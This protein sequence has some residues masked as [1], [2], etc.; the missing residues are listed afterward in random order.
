MEEVIWHF[1]ELTIIQWREESLELFLG[2][3]IL[4]SLR[5]IKLIR[6]DTTLDLSQKAE[7]AK[8][9]VT[10]SKGLEE[11]KNLIRTVGIP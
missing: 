11:A 6:T 3:G 7:K 9:K 1:K 4:H 5:D 10:S 8:V 2:L